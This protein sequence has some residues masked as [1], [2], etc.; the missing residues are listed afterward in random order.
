MDPEPKPW[1]DPLYTDPKEHELQRNNRTQ[2]QNQPDAH[3]PVKTRTLETETIRTYSQTCTFSRWTEPPPYWLQSLQPSAVAAVRTNPEVSVLLCSLSSRTPSVCFGT[4]LIRGAD[5]GRVRLAAVDT[6]RA[7]SSMK[8]HRA[9]S[10]CLAKV[11]LGL[12][13]FQTRRAAQTR[14]FSA[15]GTDIYQGSAAARSAP[16]DSNRVLNLA[17]Y[18]RRSGHWALLMRP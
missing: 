8:A 4:G 10:K 3:D 18:V 7:K 5:E 1:S 11:T 14:H 2:N 17:N 15:A 16:G 9:L 6:L 13:G 12:L